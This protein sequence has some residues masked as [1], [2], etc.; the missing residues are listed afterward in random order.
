MLQRLLHFFPGVEIWMLDA[1]EDPF[2][3]GN[4]NPYRGMTDNHAPRTVIWPME[5]LL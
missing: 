2:Y 1:A 4:L 5:C 3:H